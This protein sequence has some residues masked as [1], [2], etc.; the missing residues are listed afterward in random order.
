VHGILIAAMLTLVG[1]NGSGN[2]VPAP[3]QPPSNPAQISIKAADWDLRRDANGHT[4]L[5]HPSPDRRGG[6]LFDFFLKLPRLPRQSV[7]YLVTTASPVLTQGQ[8]VRMVGDT[9]NADPL[10]GPPPQCRIYLQ[11]ADDNLSGHGQYA[12]YRWWSTERRGDMDFVVDLEPEFWSAVNGERGDASAAA[13]AGFQQALAN[14]QSIGI[15]CVAKY[16]GGNNYSGGILAPNGKIVAPDYYGRIVGPTFS[17]S[18]FALCGGA[19]PPPL[20]VRDVLAA[21]TGEIKKIP[22]RNA[23]FRVHPAQVSMKVADWRFEGIA[24]QPQQAYPQAFQAW[25][26]SGWRV[27][28]PAGSSGVYRVITAKSPVLLQGHYLKMMGSI[29]PPA[30]AVEPFTKPLTRTAAQ[31][32]MYVSGRGQYPYEGWWSTEPLILHGG[33]FVQFVGLEPEFWSAKNGERGDANAAAKARFQRAL[34][35]PQ[36]IGFMCSGVSGST[37]KMESFAVCNPFRQPQ[38]PLRDLADTNG[39]TQEDQRCAPLSFTREP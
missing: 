1:D 20:P 30:K 34:A 14:A 17:M 23:C 31:C 11:E 24:S 25:D 3:T 7:Y 33:P 38:R 9:R 15:M 19:V 32:R 22:D 29:S 6:W 27:R 5:S 18:S 16:V 37:I 8:Y 12:Y 2:Q 4:L 36:S 10:A 35:S 13:T 39:A 28:F 26:E 21:D